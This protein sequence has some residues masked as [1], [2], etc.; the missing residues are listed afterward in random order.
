[1]CY[2]AVMLRDLMPEKSYR[3]MQVDM[4][5][6][7]IRDESR[8]KELS[9]CVVWIEKNFYIPEL[10]GTIKLLP[11]Q[12]AVL[13]E[14]QRK[15][16]NGKF[17]YS[18]VV[19]SD[20]KKSAKSTIAAALALYIAHLRDWCSVKI[21]A[22]DLKQADSRVA[23]YLRRAIELNPRM[24][25]IK[26]VRYKTT[27]PGVS[28]TIE[29][30]PIDPAGEAGGN[31]DLLIFSEMWAAK[32]KAIQQMWTEMTISPTKYGY[33]QR[34][35]ETYAGYT[36]ESPIL[37]RLYRQGI[38]EGKQLDLSYTD[39]DDKHHDLKDL[40]VYANGSLLCFWNNRPRCPWQSPEYYASEATVLTD[41]EFN[42]IHRNQWA[43]SVDTFVPPEWWA[44]C[45][46]VNL[47]PMKDNEPM[48]VALDAGVS[49]DNFSI[50]GV[51]KYGEDK[52]AVRYSRRW[53]PPKG[54]K[55]LFSNPDNP[56]DRDTPEGEVRYLCNKYN[57][58]MVAYDPYQLEDMAARLGRIQ[59]IA[60]FYAFNQGAARLTADSNLR[61]LIK[62]RRIV[63][64]GHVD[65]AEHVGNAGAKIDNEDHKIRIVKRSNQLK[66][67]MC[68]SLSMSC[69]RILYLNI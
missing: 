67:D 11:Y 3:E 48:V 51:S 30:I 15:D 69:D 27:I 54:G 52:A 25:D 59:G 19:W 53:I 14:S 38:G 39:K 20:I 33:S 35:I 42:R 47:E 9:D 10:K 29:A 17:I 64:N 37:E 8:K 41:E 44:A 46:D 21:I 56:E 55:I 1:L 57:V 50:V 6:R 34:W 23:F 62:E 32:H 28:S 31:D 68:V 16:E 2:N 5:K 58:I 65:L 43:S 60:W 24:T 12:K 13:R 22:N 61:T 26:Q 7:R 45:E 18:V 63:Y 66:V 36:G 49:G 4:I 40:E